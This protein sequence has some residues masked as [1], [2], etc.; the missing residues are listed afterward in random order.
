M[1]IV[2]EKE[3][4]I[5]DNENE[6]I[7]Y[8]D[9]EIQIKD[10]EAL[11]SV[12]NKIEKNVSQSD[13]KK[14]YNL[15]SYSK[16]I[17]SLDLQLLSHKNK[18]IKQNSNNLLEDILTK[19]SLNGVN[20]VMP[21]LLDCLENGKW[22]SQQTCLNMINNLSENKQLSITRN[23]ESIIP[24]VSD[25]M[26]STK[27]QIAD[28]SMKTMKVISLTSNNKD[29]EPFIDQI[30][31]SVLEPS[32]VTKCIH[33]LA[34]TV[35][36]QKVETPALTII[37]PLVLRG[38]KEKQIAIK[39]KVGT[40]I[41]NMLVLLENPCNVSPFIERVLPNLKLASETLT[42]EEA[43]EVVEK[44]YSRLFNISEELNQYKNISSDVILSKLEKECCFA[45]ILDLDKNLLIYISNLCSFLVTKRVY[46]EET[47]RDV[48]VN[49]LPSDNDV[50]FK[51][52]WKS[53]ISESKPPEVQEDIEE[54]GEDLC[55]C[56]F[57]L[58]Y[59][60]KVLLSNTRLHLKRG[61]RYGLVGPNDCG[62]ST[63]MRSI[64]NGQ[65]EGFP[66]PDELRTVYV[67]H[68]I[69]GID[70]DIS[71]LEFVQQDSKCQNIPV[72]E[73]ISVLESVGFSTEKEVS[74]GASQSMKI[75]SLSGGWKM[76]L[77]LA[78]AMLAKAD[79]LLLDEPTNHL[80]VAN[81][82]WVKNYLNSL[83]Q[84]TSILVSHDSGFMDNVC[85]H[86]IHFESKKLK[87]YIGNLNDF[88]KK[89][90]SA[91]SY[92][93]FKSDKLKFIFPEPTLL[94]GIK[95]KGKPILQMDNIGFTY[96]GSHKAVLNDV[97]VRCTLNSR[98]AVIGPNGAGK[99]TA[100]KVLT[101]ELTP[102]IGKVWKHPSMRFAY[103]AQNSFH[104]LENHLDKT[105]VEYIIW[106]Y[107]VGYDRELSYRENSKLTPEELKTVKKPIT[108]KIEEGGK[109]VEKKLVVDRLLARRK[110]KTSYDYQVKWEGLDESKASFVPRETLEN[111]GFKKLINLCDEEE[112][113]RMSARPCTKSF[114][115]K[116]MKEFGL[117]E[118]Y[119]AHVQISDLSGGQKVKVVLGAGLWGIPHLVI[120]D[121]PTNYL[122][123]DSLAALA[124]AIKDFEGGVVLISHNK[125]FVEHVCKT[126]WIMS[127]GRLRKEGED[128]ED[129]KI[130]EKK[131]DEE[132]TD[133]LG[134]TVKNKIKKDLSKSEIKK[135][136][137]MIN[138]KLKEGET[139]TEEEEN[140][141]IEHNL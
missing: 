11:Q 121:E 51:N 73:I 25:L 74:K 76:K 45:D 40:I 77:A 100:I 28:L 98:I 104:H 97:S 107:G 59:A 58:G 138:S 113:S 129:E 88:V 136:K 112:N 111:L 106:R 92:Y 126:L 60:S 34:S 141:C 22:E 118:E 120:L 29:L 95:S 75:T 20:L 26:V 2:S 43:K 32:E 52:I 67:E 1:S 12:I 68:D 44:S 122:D 108:I 82:E 8:L 15:V 14:E 49:Y 72:E 19:I 140:F 24:I 101:G 99:S 116:H 131:L 117:D 91:K 69:Q 39:R 55:N 16:Y 139:L 54:E 47:W 115:I 35:F 13:L 36:V 134:N 61:K 65:L 23:L 21:Y 81:V 3:L 84:V 27:K 124:T 17:L 137:K 93:E 42:D 87:T 33:G 64:A 6:F 83:T 30:I 10:V 110:K 37:E 4:Q 56:E 133:Y 132:T 31:L 102:D 127:D 38:L 71:V 78:R 109:M 125:D 130:V 105:P 62:K 66:S 41:E 85:T 128:D 79:I 70:T 63:L 103:V 57:T 9:N 119:S 5:S 86:I 96:P 48:I 114:V 80:D 94:D 89:N 123:R 7:N 135:M 90:P 53:C 46:D 50:I 18:Q